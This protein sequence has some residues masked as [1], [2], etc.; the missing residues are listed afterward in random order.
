MPNHV[1][2]W[3]VRELDTRLSFPSTLRR[4]TMVQRLRKLYYVLVFAGILSACNTS[5]PTAV[6]TSITHSTTTTTSPTTST[7]TASTQGSNCTTKYAFTQTSLPSP[8]N[9]ASSPYSS[10]GGILSG[11]TNS[12]AVYISV[13]PRGKIIGIAAPLGWKC[14]AM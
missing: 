1:N 13:G 5:Y 2:L 8:P 10:G 14:N 12:L 7:S 4:M 9:F 11:Y 6:T 3:N